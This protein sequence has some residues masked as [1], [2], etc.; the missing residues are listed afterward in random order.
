V[1]HSR[2]E[3][4][5]RIERRVRGERRKKSLIPCSTLHG[6]LFPHHSSLGNLGSDTHT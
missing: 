1:E 4:K 2:D 6:H 3:K 5:K